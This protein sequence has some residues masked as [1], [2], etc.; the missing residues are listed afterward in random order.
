MQARRK[1][2][3]RNRRIVAAAVVAAAAFVAPPA[4]AQDFF[5]NRQITLVIGYNPGGSYDV[6]ATIAA[7]FL[8]RFIPGEP[9]VVAK[10][11]P[12]VGGLKAASYLAS[13]AS[14]DGLTIG[15]VSQAVALKQVLK[16]A[17]VEYDAR[18]FAWIGRL[19]PAVEVTIASRASGVRT[20]EDAKRRD[21]V[22]A[23]TSAGSTTDLM[24]R[25][26][27]RFAGTRFKIVKGYPGTTGATLAMER[28]EADASHATADNLLF[29]KPQWLRDG[30]VSV[31][32]QYAQRRHPAFPDVP[33]MVDVA[34][35]ARDRSVLELFGGTADVGRALMTPP[36]VPPER[37]AILRR[38][39]DAMVADPAFR[40]EFATRNLELIPLR[41]AELQALVTR[42][43]DAPADVAQQAMEIA[44]Q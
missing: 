34:T 10:F 1:P 44:A 32:V 37:L 15:M 28:G 17:T 41:G 11:M 30:V 16:D 20:L 31:L 19:A 13:Q 24:P 23:A 38:A 29:G 43:L 33:A 5:R 39:F 40:H 35:N 18:A 7:R 36:D 14:R 4:S 9:T 8:P 25:L 22:L 21:V 6:T 12:G 27:N 42:T 26:M 3:A 2:I